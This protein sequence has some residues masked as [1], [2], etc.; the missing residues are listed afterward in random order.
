M[1]PPS[2]QGLASSQLS[3]ADDPV[4]KRPSSSLVG[5]SSSTSLGPGPSETSGPLP[6]KD[7][8]VLRSGPGPEVNYPITAGPIGSADPISSVPV[9]PSASQ[10][11]FKFKFQ[12]TTLL[13]VL[14]GGK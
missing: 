8:N 12:K 14:R 9:G 1:R 4:S 10:T 6:K 3:T 5:P 7:C 2:S 11:K 13:T